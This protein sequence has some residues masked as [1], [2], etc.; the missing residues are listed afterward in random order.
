[1]CIRDS[2]TIVRSHFFDRASLREIDY[3]TPSIT[4]QQQCT[5]FRIDIISSRFDSPDTLGNVNSASLRITVR[6]VARWILFSQEFPYWA[7]TSAGSVTSMAKAGANYT[8]TA[9]DNCH[10]LHGKVFGDQRLQPQAHPCLGAI[11]LF[12]IVTSLRGIH[13]V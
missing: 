6:T 9:V 5:E 8:R 10:F 2:P 7:L 3:E 1:M 4:S 13:S 12:S 11:L